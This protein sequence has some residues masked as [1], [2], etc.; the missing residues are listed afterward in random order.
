MKREVHSILTVKHFNSFLVV[1][2]FFETFVTYCC[3]LTTDLVQC[4]AQCN[5]LHLHL[6][7]EQGVSIDKQQSHGLSSAPSHPAGDLELSL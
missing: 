7:L 1:S 4:I 2:M 6:P 5:T 3:G